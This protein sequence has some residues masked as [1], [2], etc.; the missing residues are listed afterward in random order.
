MFLDEKRIIEAATRCDWWTFADRTLQTIAP[1]EAY[2]HKLA[3]WMR[4]PTSSIDARKVN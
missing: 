1:Q 4:S 2:L 3:T